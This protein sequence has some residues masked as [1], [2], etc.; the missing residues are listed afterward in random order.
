MS[1]CHGTALRPLRLS[2]RTQLW[3]GRNYSAEEVSSQCWGGQRRKGL[4]DRL[5]TGPGAMPLQTEI[6][7]EVWAADRL[8]LVGKM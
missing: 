1:Q 7:R 4:Q 6:L 3:A 2:L 8:V 5:D